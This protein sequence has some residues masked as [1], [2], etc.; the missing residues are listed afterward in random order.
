[1]NPLAKSL[2][3]DGRNGRALLLAGV[4]LLL[5]GVPAAFMRAHFAY[6][7]SA[8]LHGELWRWVTAHLVHL[9]VVHAALNV[10]GLALVWALYFRAWSS[11]EWLVVIVAGMLAIDA[12]LW[13][14]QP[15]LQW[16]VGAS[17]L[18]H[19]LLIAG[20]VGQWR[21]ER[22]I[23]FV[24]GALFVAKLAWEWRNGALPF[25][26]ESAHVVLPA[27]RY[28]AAGGAIASV[29]LTLRRKWL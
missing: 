19:G 17:G 14:W 26:G 16:Y 25:A 22:G 18:L 11:R 27:H 6:D 28:G 24:V 8:L 7:R 23:A 4:A 15:Q 2:N 21:N 10:L 3:C 29:V 13:W 5:L 9:D 12:G 1:M 20:V